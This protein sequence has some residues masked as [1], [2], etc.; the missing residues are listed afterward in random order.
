[1]NRLGADSVSGSQGFRTFLALWL[2]AWYCLFVLA[3]LAGFCLA[4][5]FELVYLGHPGVFTLAGVALALLAVRWTWYLIDRGDAPGLVVEE[6]D[7]PRLLEMV[8]QAA[9]RVGS[10]VPDRVLVIP[11]ATIVCV[12]R[13]RFPGAFWWRELRI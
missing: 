5:V 7:Q 13:C 1:M 2:I 10:R 9:R 12:D 6:H 8:R 4:L 11:D 3:A